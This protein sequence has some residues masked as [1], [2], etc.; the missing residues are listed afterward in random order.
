[1][2]YLKVYTDFRELMEP[3][4]H[5]EAGRLFRAMLCYAEDGTEAP[6]E[7]NERFVWAMARR[8]IDREAAACAQK[9]EVNRE[10]GRKGAQARWHRTKLKDGEGSQ[11]DGQGSERHG[12]HGENSQ[13]KDKEKENENESLKEYMCVSKENEPSDGY[14]HIPSREE[15]E[16]YCRE[17]G[18]GIDPDYF[19]DYYAAAG[20]QVGQNPVRDWRALVRAWEKRDTRRSVPADT[21]R[22]SPDTAQRRRAVRARNTLLNCRETPSHPSLESIAFDPDEL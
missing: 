11:D 4:N 17:R 7:G 21:A 16:A 15:I 6:L 8:I 10:N 3:L 13:D 2:T 12:D 22:G 19:H 9:A 14:T 1:M 5:E 20:W 18:N